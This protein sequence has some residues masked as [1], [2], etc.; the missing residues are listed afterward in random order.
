[1]ADITLNDAARQK[2]ANTLAEECDANPG[3]AEKAAMAVTQDE[4]DDFDDWDDFV[5]FVH[6]TD[7]F[8]D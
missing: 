8:W 3:E 1:M 4:A 6:E 2:L 5:E 7:R